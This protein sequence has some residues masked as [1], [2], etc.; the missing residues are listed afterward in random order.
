[1]YASFRGIWTF[2]FTYSAFYRGTPDD[3]PGINKVR[4]NPVWE[5]LLFATHNTSWLIKMYVSATRKLP[6]CKQ[7]N[8]HNSYN[9]ND[10]IISQTVQYSVIIFA[11]V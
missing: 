4:R 3:V 1:M 7:T 2:S 8:A 11:Q 6:Q 10:A 5:A 9:H